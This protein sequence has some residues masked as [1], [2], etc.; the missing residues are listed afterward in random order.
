MTLPLRRTTVIEIDSAHSPLPL[1]LANA[2]AAKIAADL[3]ARV[4]KLEPPGGDPVRRL[5]PYIGDGH[6]SALFHFLNTSKHSLVL[7]TA[8]APVVDRLLAGKVDAVL[9][10]AGEPGLALAGAG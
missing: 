10:E 7:P 9:A 1:R 3:G 8:Q 4:I 6:E 5:P 2:L